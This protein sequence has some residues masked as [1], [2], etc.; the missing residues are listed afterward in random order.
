MQDWREMWPNNEIH[1]TAVIC[2]SVCMGKGNYIGP[3]TV[4]GSDVTLGDNNRITG[5]CSIGSAPEH[6]DYFDGRHEFGTV[7]GSGNTIREFTTI[8]SGTV[9]HTVMGDDCI[10][11]RGSHLSHDS[12]LENKVTLSCNVLIGGHS[13]IMEGANLGLGA[14]LHQYSVVGAYAML[15]MGT[16][17]TKRQTIKPGNIY[18]GNPSRLLCENEIGLT[19]GGI[20]FAKQAGFLDR[21]HKL[22][23]ESPLA[24]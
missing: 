13:Y 18:V 12:V 20:D 8:N 16:V 11:L 4:I 22:W 6:K 1:Q 15:G 2:T 19:R 10:M 7:I 24:K 9:R 23:I 14:I 21:F 5:H 3:Y 17:V